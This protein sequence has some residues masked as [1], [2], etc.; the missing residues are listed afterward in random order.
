MPKKATKTFL[1]IDSN[2]LLHRSYHALPP[3]STSDG[4][5]VNAV[6]GFVSTVLKTMKEYSPTHIAAAFDL[7][8]GTFRHELFVAYKGT[9]EVAEQDLY[10]QFPIVKDVLQVMNI[11][12]V[13][14]K[15]YE[16]DDIIGTLVSQKE[17]DVDYLILTSDMDALQL[18]DDSI[19]VIRLRKGVTD[20]AYFDEK[21]VKEKYGLTPKQ[22]VDFKALRGDPSDNI[23]GVKGVGEKT[24]TDLLQTFKTLDA[25]YHA[26]EKQDE[27]IKGAVL[28]KLQDDKDNAYLSQKLARIEIQ[29]PIE[30][31]LSIYK[32]KGVDESATRQQFQ[33]LEFKSLLARLPKPNVDELAVIQHTQTKKTGNETYTL[34]DTDEDFNTCI[35]TLAK[36]QAYAVDTETTGTNPLLVDLLGISLSWKKGEAYYL[37][38]SKHKKWLLKLAPLFADEKT[39]KFGHNI[40][41]DMHVLHRAG[42]PLKGVMF[43]TMIA[44]YLIRPGIRQYSLDAV[45]FKEIG[46]TMKPIEELIGKKGKDQLTLDHVPLEEVSWYACEDADF[47]FQLVDILSAQLQEHGLVKLFEEIEMPLVEELR[48]VEANGVCIDTPFLKTMERSM[49]QKISNVQ[50]NIFE[51]AGREFNIKSPLQLKEILFDELGISVEGLSKTKTGVSTAASELEKLEGKHPIIDGIMQYREFTKL[52]STYVK[53]LPKLVNPETK[54]LHTS[55]NQTITATGRL[56]SSD[57]NLQNIPIRTEL[58]NEIRKAFVA[59]KG[60]ILLSADYSQVEL[61]IVASLAKD[62]KMI[63]AFSV[64]EDIHSRTAAYMFDVPLADVTKEMRYSAKEVNFGVLYGMGVYGLAARRKISREKARVFIEKY[65]TVYKGV[66]QFLEEIRAKAQDQGYVETM[67]GRKRY[68]P[69]MY[70][71]MRQLRAQA[72]RMAVNFPVQGSAADIMKIAMIR[73]AKKLEDVSK[74]TKMILQVHDELVFDVPKSDREK[75][76]KFV[77]K[78]MESIVRLSVPLLVEVHTG[79]NWG[80]LE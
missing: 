45:V 60:N 48:A 11:P 47:T 56:S 42:A 9:R 12:I 14:K 80:S 27:R 4:T 72:E 52:Q 40:K 1:V 26:V 15:N 50:K 5:I 75:V 39:K 2:A 23:P 67:F 66:Y 55:Y 37:N 21:E 30:T 28:K 31:S 70:S 35:A 18:V 63:E 53:T 19:Q 7:D 43:D 29:V 68:L 24:A 61:R 8:G 36:Q 16:A 46:Y 20:L 77:K 44:A 62:E 6:Y 71:E 41:Y 10:D 57:P 17:K 22:I 25:I 58:G 32:W 73:I 76:G 38:V 78:E 34:I 33:L 49:A 3:F 54:R 51:Y 79:N 64:G 59:S 13:E 65:F 74:D 69:E